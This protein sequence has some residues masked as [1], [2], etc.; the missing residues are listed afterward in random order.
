MRDL[1]RGA[2]SSTGS[3]IIMRYGT[4]AIIGR[5]NVGKSTFLNTALGTPLAI[6]SHQPQTTRDTLLGVVN[7]DIA[8][9]AFVDTPGFHRAKNELGRRMNHFAVDALR[10]ADV[11]LFVTDIHQIAGE[12]NTGN[13]TTS[14]GA[15]APSNPKSS[16]VDRKQARGHERSDRD[17]IEMLPEELPTIL[18]IN[19][20][21]KLKDKGQ[22][23]PYL[24]R[25]NEYF[26]FSATVPISALREDGVDRVLG[27]LAKWV[28][29]SER[30]FDSDEM[31][32]RPITFFAR[33][34]IREQVLALVSS[35]VPHASAVTLDAVEERE[36]GLHV[37]ATIHVEKVGQRIILVGRGGQMVKEIGTAARQRLSELTGQPVHLK[38]FVRVTD[39]WRNMPRQLS[40]L[41]Y[42]PRS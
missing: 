20:I 5:T 40:E 24:A 35:E 17:L 7:T 6:V 39:R 1:T 16:G 4:I 33:E 11:A 36:T 12:M 30:H 8:Q 19:K 26:P 38:L 28:P 3:A 2:F 22:L 13:R 29:E 15:K 37:S 32:D 21:D 25:M 9:L 41:G 34:Y 18:V 10:G 23:L 14:D 31:T 27:E 42:D